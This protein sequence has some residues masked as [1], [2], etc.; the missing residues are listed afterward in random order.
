M[1]TQ[2]MKTNAK[3]WTMSETN[4]VKIEVPMWIVFKIGFALTNGIIV[5]IGFAL[6]VNKLVIWIL[7]L[8]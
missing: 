3:T 4:Q 1:E 5:G 8:L 2:T 7:G 6:A